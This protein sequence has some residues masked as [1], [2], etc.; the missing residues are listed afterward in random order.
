MTRTDLLHWLLAA[1]LGVLALGLIYFVFIGVRAIFRDARGRALEAGHRP[2]AAATRALT[3]MALWAACFAAFYLYLYFLGK[4]LEAWAVLPGLL[5]LA[6]LIWGLLQADRLLTVPSHNV[7]A[8]VGIAASLAI[9][10][11]AY[12]SAAWYAIYAA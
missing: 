2:V 9:L 12:G 6:A 3:R 7:R 1:G 4:R 10:L 11:G 8:H 5:G